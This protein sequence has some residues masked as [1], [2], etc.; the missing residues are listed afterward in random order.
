[1]SSLQYQLGHPTKSVQPVKAGA[2]YNLE[3]VQFQ[4]RNGALYRLWD[5]HI[6]LP[7]SWDI[8]S[9]GVSS[10]WLGY[11]AAPPKEEKKCPG[12]MGHSA[13]YSMSS[14]PSQQGHLIEYLQPQ[15]AGAF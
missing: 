13:P 2:F 10:V 12:F 9:G 11:P 8:L 5:E 4:K 1:M 14:L 6:Q 3:Y 7:E 15:K